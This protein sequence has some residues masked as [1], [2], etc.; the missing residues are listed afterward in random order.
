[1]QRLTGLQWVNHGLFIL[2]GF[3]SALDAQN[4]QVIAKLNDNSAGNANWRETRLPMFRGPDGRGA[5]VGDQPPPGFGGWVDEFFN[6]PPKPP[7]SLLAVTKTQYSHLKRWAD[8]TFDADW[9]P[10]VPPPPDRF[11]ALAPELQIKHLERAPLHDCLG[12]PFHPAM[13]M[14]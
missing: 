10:A 1:F 12:G 6:D 5:L 2:H 7:N 13:E 3:G 8:G 14:T 9:S 11:S 4:P